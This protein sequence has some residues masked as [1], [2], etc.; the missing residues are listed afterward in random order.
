MLTA[1][2]AS[3]RG[4][5]CMYQGEELGL[6][7]ASVAFEDL[8]DPYGIT[9]WPN[10]KGRD[11][12]RT[13]MPWENTLSEG[14]PSANAGFSQAKPWL[15]LDPAHK[16]Q[17]VA[18]QDTDTHSILNA[19][20]EFM[21]W[22]KDQAILLEGDITFIETQEPVLA[23]IRTLGTQKMLCVFN[24]GFVQES[25]ALSV[26]VTKEYTELTHHN[27]KLNNELLLLAPYGCYY[28]QCT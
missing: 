5:V 13:P 19:Y 17:A 7:E 12:C 1:L 9:F 8:Q 26:P 15:P 4:S 18:V 3:L 22:R 11:G 27:G 6:G 14:E 21:A 2:L 20:R 10:F 25:L 24:L 16:S 28:A 23:F